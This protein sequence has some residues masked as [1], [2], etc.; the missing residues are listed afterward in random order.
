[1]K[2]DRTHLVD[3][4][5]V[6]MV[7]FLVADELGWLYRSQE[8]SDMGIDAHFEVVQGGQATGRLLAVQIK[9]GPSWF[10][11]PVDGGWWF[12]CNAAHMEYWSNGS[13]PVVIALFHP[14]TRAVYWQHVNETTLVSTG[15]G[16][17]VLV[18]ASQQL[19]E[20]CADALAAP[21]R[22]SA[23]TETFHQA[24][25]RLPAD[26]RSALMRAHEADAAYAVQMAVTLADAVNPRALLRSLLASPPPWLAGLQETERAGAWRALAGYAA[27]HE[28]GTDAVDALERAANAEPDA[29][30]A[31]RLR[32]LAAILAAAAD[33]DRARSLIEASVGRVP[34]LAAVA[35][36]LVRAG[37]QPSELPAVVA[38]AL[39]QGDEAAVGE[40]TVLRFVAHTHFAAGHYDQGLAALERAAQL[41]PDFPG[42]LV[43]LAQA[44]MWHATAGAATLAYLDS[45]R[46]ERLAVAARA[47][48]RRWGG[49]GGDAALV[50]LRVRLMGDTIAAALATAIPAPDGEA[51]GLEADYEP[52]IL[53]AGRAAYQ[54]GQPEAAVR[55]AARLTDRGARAQLAAMAMDTDPQTGTAQRVEAWQQALD[56]ATNDDQRGLAAFALTGLGVWPI[57]ALDALREQGA[58]SEVVYQVRWACAQDA[59]GDRPAAIRRLRQWE[60]AGPVAALA[61]VAFVDDREAAAAIAERAG[62]RFGDLA[63]RVHAVQLWEEAGQSDLA[64]L[65]ALTLLAR[66]HLPVVMRRDLRG[67][68]VRWAQDRQDWID[69]EDHALAGLTEELTDEEAAPGTAHG[70]VDSIAAMFAWA[71]V[72]A[73][74]ANRRLDAAWDTI[75]RFTP[76]I[77]SA[78]EAAMWLTLMDWGGWTVPRVEQALEMVTRLPALGSRT[79]A[80]ILHAAGGDREE[81]PD[82]D[83]STNSGS[84]AQRVRLDLP[85]PLHARAL[86][87]LDP[88]AAEVPVLGTATSPEELADFVLRTLGPRQTVIDQ[89]ADAVRIGAV[90][91]GVLAQAASRPHALA[92]V[93]RPAGLIP[94][95]TRDPQAFQAEVR[96]AYEA[97]ERDVVLDLSAIAVATLL[98]E[99]IAQLRAVFSATTTPTAVHDDLV[100]TVY[101]CDSL[102]RSSGQ[103]GVRTGDVTL[104]VLSPQNKRDVAQRSA[105][106]IRLLP[107]LAVQP[108]DNLDPLYEWLPFTTKPQAEQMPWL[109]AAQLAL[110][111]GMALWCDDPALRQ[112]LI[113]SGIQTFGTVALLQVLATHPDYPQFTSQQLS[114]DRRTLMRAWVVDLPF[115]QDDVIDIAR[116]EGWRPGSAAAPFDRPTFWATEDSEAIWSAAIARIW[117]EAPTE[118]AGWHAAAL[119][120]C[121]SLIEPHHVAAA[122]AS[123]TAL[124]LLAVGL[125][126]DPVAAVWPT[127][128][129]SL[130][131]GVRTS[132]QRWSAVGSNKEAP[133]PDPDAFKD[134]VRT[135]LIARLRQ[136]HGFSPSLATSMADAALGAAS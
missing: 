67:R 4:A 11:E 108:V 35:E 89:V 114:D 70:P 90:P 21:A 6:G 128:L 120:G 32:A 68:A 47:E 60:T 94:A 125:G 119:R 13:L 14:G 65:R 77:G 117:D 72:H 84:G 81:P 40:S 122:Q 85:Q 7:S 16:W 45:R 28:L 110:T 78:P 75:S 61:L 111:N 30:A 2:V 133:V 86:E 79:A 118:L 66:P 101:A 126:P 105:A 121:S 107:T 44:L 20:R 42:L 53:D 87:L 8:T 24:L 123:L 57:P 37:G 96:A 18:P 91:M 10:S 100:N 33:T 80:A 19:N 98:P 129:S 9:S 136:Q 112:L 12:R 88:Q 63:L 93:Q 95:A 69:M 92:Y 104:T 41:A 34:V 50:L 39:D 36:A 27:A 82:P 15:K 135:Q 127:V 113:P 130:E 25:D 55:F 29:D 3:R 17:K 43:D 83:I 99:R 51:I 26:P 124:T 31:A 131:A 71:A 49:P 56:T 22:R 52:L 54:A 46:A 106:F 134:L 38:E 97:L 73:Q 59:A 109:H 5:G 1:M 58:L 62:H 74:L 64:R 102:L 116:D 76:V 103:L 115:D 23:D 48:Y 132:I